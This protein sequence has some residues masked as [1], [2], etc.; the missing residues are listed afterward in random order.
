[1]WAGLLEKQ[2]SLIS[3]EEEIV[4]GCAAMVACP[5]F[6]DCSPEPPGRGRIIRN[7]LGWSLQEET[8]R[9]GCSVVPSKGRV[10]SLPLSQQETGFGRGRTTQHGRSLFCSSCTCSY[11][12]GQGPAVRPHAGKRC[13]PLL[14]GV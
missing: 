10:F 9:S 13:W 8:D 4:P 11:A 2:G 3:R 1:M 5:T 12:Y 14:A 6:S 7:M